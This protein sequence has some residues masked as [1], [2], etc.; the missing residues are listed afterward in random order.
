MKFTTKIVSLALAAFV[1]AAMS[2]S[3]AAVDETTADATDAAKE[4]V[5][6][7]SSNDDGIAPQTAEEND[8]VPLAAEGGDAVP[9]NETGAAAAD[10]TAETTAAE[11]SYRGY[12]WHLSLYPQEVE[13]EVIQNI[14]KIREASARMP[15]FSF[16]CAYFYC[17]NYIA[18]TSPAF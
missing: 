7:E 1:T 15:P 13:E 11:T 4:S 5:A 18:D 14:I 3:V 8:A 9:T 6:V 2:V 12:R 16:C 17:E 10:T